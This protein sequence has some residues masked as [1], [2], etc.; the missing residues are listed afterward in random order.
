MRE[1][2]VRLLWFSKCSNLPLVATSN[3]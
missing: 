1:Q 3:V 2:F